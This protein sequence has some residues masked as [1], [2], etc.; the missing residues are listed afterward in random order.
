MTTETTEM[1]PA[2]RQA[3]AQV[4]AMRNGRAL[5]GLSVA[6]R[7]DLSAHA[8][9]NEGTLNNAQ[10]ERQVNV[11]AGDEVVLVNAVSGDVLK[12]G[13]IDH[14][15]TLALGA[16]A[17]LPIC[18]NCRRGD[19]NRI[20]EDAQFKEA[21][22]GIDKTDNARVVDEVVRRCVIDDL[23]GL[24]VTQGNRNAPRRS[25]AQFGWLLGVPDHVRTGSYTHVKLVPGAAE[26]DTG[27][28]NRGQN[29]FKR[30]AS[31][32]QYA[33]VTQVSL[34]RIGY[35]D[36]SAR[37]VVDPAERANR[38]RAALQALYL[39]L[40]APTGAQRNTQLPHL[41]GAR[42]VVC[43]AFGSTPPVLFSPLQDDF[44]TQMGAIADAFG[45]AERGLALVEFGTVGELGQILKAAT[46][47]VG[48]VNG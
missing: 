43:L 39:T 46:D 13:F 18:E 47:W 20:N 27:G 24:L 4:E 23:G 33:F 15:R 10:I 45:R 34:G 17:G 29:L 44:V 22:K 28:S 11:V 7:A 9:N 40:A 37:Y 32:G 26:E 48:P 16:G 36:I 30:P 6:A 14:L 3:L 35:N 31:S 25:V 21:L 1:T 5:T 38:A 19:P 2:M 42:G 12:H 41:Q 8:L